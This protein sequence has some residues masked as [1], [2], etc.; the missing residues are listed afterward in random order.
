M[1]AKLTSTT[2]LASPFFKT[3]SGLPTKLHVRSQLLSWLF[4]CWSEEDVEADRS[5]KSTACSPDDGYAK[6]AHEQI[7]S[8]SLRGMLKFNIDSSEAI[9]LEQVEPWTEI[10]QR[11]STGAMSYGSVSVVVCDDCG[12]V[13]RADSD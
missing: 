6:N 8:T 2:L 7:K 9:P 11:F 1:E 10:V 4:L 5:F 3:L 12:L 13:Q